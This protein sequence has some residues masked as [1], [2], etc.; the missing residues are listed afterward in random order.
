MRKGTCPSC[1]ALKQMCGWSQSDGLL[2]SWP[3]FLKIEALLGH[4]PCVVEVAYSVYRQPGSRHL[5]YDKWEPKDL[6]QR[7]F[8]RL[9][10]IDRRCHL[11]TAAAPGTATPVLCIDML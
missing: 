10:V 11:Q 3:L 8:G 1:L 4:L 9:A 2:V 7:H 5:V 6:D